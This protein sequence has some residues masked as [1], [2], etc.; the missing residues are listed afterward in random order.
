[1]HLFDPYA[2]VRLR[3]LISIFQNYAHIFRHIPCVK[4]IAAPRTR[5]CEALKVWTVETNP[6]AW[7][8]ANAV[9]AQSAGRIA[10]FA[11]VEQASELSV[12]SWKKVL[13]VEP[14]DGHRALW[15]G[16]KVSY[17]SILIAHGRLLNSK[18]H[19]IEGL[20]ILSKALTDSDTAL[21]PP[22]KGAL[23]YNSGDPRRWLWV[24]EGKHDLI[25]QS[26]A[27]Y[28]N[29]LSEWQTANDPNQ[30]ALVQ[31]E[32]AY[33]EASHA[34]SLSDKTALRAAEKSAS[35]AKKYIS[36]FGTKNATARAVYV[37]FEIEGLRRDWDTPS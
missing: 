5:R 3:K 21:S 28:K 29:S 2:D 19:V 25:D 23:Y 16:R 4:V 34:W 15:A 36:K 1:L 31:L 27:D 35:A 26:V 24:L 20:E 10:N 12:A 33:S 14:A 17:G 11:S 9:I 13:S 37:L 32:L 6:Q 8:D 22:A 18:P 30:I 7:G